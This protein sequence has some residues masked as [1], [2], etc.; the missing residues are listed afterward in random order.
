MEQY[1]DMKAKYSG[2]VLFLRLGDFYEMF[3][4]DAVKA[5]PVLE[6]VLTQRT[7]IPMC[8]VPYHSLNSYIR[9]LITKGFKVAI[10]EQLEESGISKGIVKR[11]VTK[12]LTPGT[13]LEDALLESKKNNFLMSVIFDDAAAFATF[14]AADISTGEFFVSETTSKSIGAEISKYNI[15]ELIISAVNMQNK[16]ISDF[17]A[18]LKVTVSDIDNS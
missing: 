17:T 8:G 4:D 9:K 5:A 1:W 18:K 13:I 14:A 12:V 16:H 7:G 6:V 15:G 10:C 11:G 3:G 2:M